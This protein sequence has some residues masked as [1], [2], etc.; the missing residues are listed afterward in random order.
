MIST[1]TQMKTSNK[2]NCS[3]QRT[4]TKLRSCHCNWGP[5]ISVTLTARVQGAPGASQSQRTAK[6]LFLRRLTAAE[7]SAA[8]PPQ[9]PDSDFP[10]T[11]SENS[12]VPHSRVWISTSNNV[13]DIYIYILAKRYKV[14]WCK[15]K[16]S[17]S[18]K[19]CSSLA[20]FFFR[21]YRTHFG[22]ITCWG[23]EEKSFIHGP[24]LVIWYQNAL[25]YLE[26]TVQ[27]ILGTFNLHQE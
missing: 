9:I 25:R 12:P 24:G 16:T 19:I 10:K 5:W 8:S 7:L 14:P 1:Q 22:Y 4:V 26:D 17:V 6:M 15:N 11:P 3:L 23:K 21:L 18:P 27:R 2:T 20:G 13:T